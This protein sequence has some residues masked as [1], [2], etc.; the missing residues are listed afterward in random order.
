MQYFRTRPF[1]S[2]SFKDFPK[3]MYVIENFAIDGILLL[4]NTTG[5]IY[6]YQPNG[7]MKQVAS[8]LDEYLLG[9]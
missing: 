8:N 1:Q 2:V 7:K 4:Q 9:L 5:E 6:T 3:G